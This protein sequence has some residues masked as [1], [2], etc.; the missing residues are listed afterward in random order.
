[1][2]KIALAHD[3]LINNGGA[4]RVFQVFCEILYYPIILGIFIKKYTSEKIA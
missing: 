1:M 4:E 2:K 3:A